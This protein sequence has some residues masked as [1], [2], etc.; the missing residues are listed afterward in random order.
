MISNIRTK[1]AAV[2]VLVAAVLVGG[3][4]PADA[5]DLHAA[6]SAALQGTKAPAVGVLVMRHGKVTALAV[7]GVR[8]NDRPGPVQVGD[9]W[10]IGSDAKPMTATLI[11]RLVDRGVLNWRTPLSQLLPDLAGAMRPEYRSVTLVQ[12][13]SHQSG[14]PH[15]PSDTKFLNSL[16][17]DTRP[18]PA[19]RLA[20]VA[21]ALQDTPVAP[22]GVKF[23]Y[24]NTGF[25]LAAVIAER[26]TGVSYEDLMRREVFAPLGITSEGVGVPQGAQPRGHLDGKPVLATGDVDPLAFAP[27]GLWYLSL[28]DWAKFC[29]D[30]MAGAQGHGRLLKAATYRLMQTQQI[31]T[32]DDVIGLAWGLS[33]TAMGYAGPFLT[34]TGSDGAWLA[35]VVLLPAQN[36]GV[37]AVSNAGRSMG[38]DK[39]A[40]RA[41]KAALPEIAPPAPPSSAH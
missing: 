26:A 23:S 11:A 25:I 34:H 15:D 30:Q 6:L 7:E 40:G 33:P 4:T 41:L 36:S 31:K 35:D 22:P 20:L 39:A 37:L 8:R 12:L 14:L 2:S 17:S 19:Q 27:A 3:A 13:L 9:V 21:R 28:R 1:I 24:S 32:G 10:L 18:P 16:S 38:G 5:A 29:L